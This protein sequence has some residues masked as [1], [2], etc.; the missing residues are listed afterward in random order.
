MFWQ[1]LLVIAL[2]GIGESQMII[3]QMYGARASMLTGNY[4]IALQPKQWYFWV[5]I[6]GALTILVGYLYGITVFKN[7]WLV[8]ITSWTAIVIVEVFMSW[9]V[10]NTVPSGTVLV[11]FVLVLVGFIIANL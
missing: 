4:W 11:G 3:A 6:T 10:F 5:T 2:I 7:I 1:K 9:L 8:A